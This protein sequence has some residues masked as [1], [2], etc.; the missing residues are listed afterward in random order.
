MKIVYLSSASFADSDF[1]LIREYQNQGHD[2]YFFI[3]LPCYMLRSTIITIKEQIPHYGIFKA[4]EYKEFDLF[5]DY[6]DLSHTYVINRLNKKVFYP[7]NI[8]IQFQ[9]YNKIREINPDTIVMTGK[10]EMFACL[11]YLFRKKLVMTVHDPFP[12]TG[13]KNIRDSFFRSIAFK[14]I[15]KFILL[16]G[17]QKD[18]FL[19]A[20]RL[21]VRQICINRIG[22]YDFMN[23]F[24][25]K[26]KGKSDNSSARN[27]LFFG[28]I[29]PYKGIEYLLEAMKL[30]HNKLPDVTVTV[31]GSGK[32]YFDTSK[33]SALP[34]VRIINRFIEMSEIAELLDRCTI[35]VCPYTDATQSGVVLTA[36]AMNKPIVATQ[37]GGLGEY[38]TD[39]KTGILVPPKNVKALAD[40]IV[41]VLDDKAMLDNMTQNIKARNASEEEGWTGIVKRYIDFFTRE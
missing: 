7:K 32:M 19:K 11:I 15:P 13:E 31:A 28:R 34:Y 29:S 12:H 18:E 9:L 3:D 4:T 5:R 20:H 38:I 2:V 30:V 26:D 17:K 40:A 6:M 10:P 22:V 16:N 21:N 39:N 25:P 23:I 27:I 35:V 8:L 33:Y 37:V 41:E 14:L 1:P 36:F 24:L